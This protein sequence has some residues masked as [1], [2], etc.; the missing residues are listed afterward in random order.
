M[1]CSALSGEGIGGWVTGL[2]WC[3]TYITCHTRAMAPL[4]VGRLHAGLPRRRRRVASSDIPRSRVHRGPRR[5]GPVLRALPTPTPPG[6]VPRRRLLPGPPA[7]KDILNYWNSCFQQLQTLGA[8]T[9]VNTIAN[10]YRQCGATIGILETI[11][12]LLENYWKNGKTI[13]IVFP[14]VV[15]IFGGRLRRPDDGCTQPATP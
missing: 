1:P 15:E 8:K 5:S 10:S 2:P 14:I 7:A 11:G 6:H 13:P 3:P 4:R 12:K 9:I